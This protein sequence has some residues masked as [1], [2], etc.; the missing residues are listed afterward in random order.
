MSLIK[1]IKEYA[2]VVR[3][4]IKNKDQIID[5]LMMGAAVKNGKVSDEDLAEILRRKDICAACPF[6]SENA[7]KQGYY[8]SSI[9]FQ[10]CTLCKCRIGADDSKEYCLS[11]NCGAEAF[12][13][14]NPHLRPIDVRWKATRTEEHNNNEQ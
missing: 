10:H 12:N 6:N 8:N 11:C 7:K 13:K 1:T 3:N 14:M 5:A 9:P 4:G 2:E